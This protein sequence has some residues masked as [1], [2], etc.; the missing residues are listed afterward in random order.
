MLYLNR[1]IGFVV[2]AISLLMGC[3]SN[4]QIIKVGGEHDYTILR[5]PVKKIETNT[6]EPILKNG[7]IVKGKLF[8]SL[9]KLSGSGGKQE[10]DEAGNVIR[11]MQFKQGDTIAEFYNEYKYSNGNRIEYNAYKSP[12]KKI[13]QDKQKFEYDS[14]N[15]IIVQKYYGPSF[16]VNEWMLNRKKNFNYNEYDDIIKQIDSSF[17]PFDCNDI[18]ISTKVFNR[19]P[20]YENGLKI[21]DDS[22]IYKYDPERNLVRKNF[23]GDIQYEEFYPSGVRKKKFIHDSYYFEYNEDGYYKK[24]VH[25]LRLGHL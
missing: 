11:A 22:Y 7:D 1:K 8:N 20:K 25:S 24:R 19:H 5:G 23:K 10:F 21:E 13:K 15:R 9:K 3:T 14:R 2:I 6:Y 18:R 17:T 12:L 4:S 16:C